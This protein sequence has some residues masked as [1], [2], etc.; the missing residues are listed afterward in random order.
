MQVMV[1][2]RAPLTCQ[3]KSVAILILDSCLLSQLSP[4][5]IFL[6]VFDVILNMD[7]TGSAMPTFQNTHLCG[8]GATTGGI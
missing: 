2:S 4:L 7:L 5:N 3:V 1:S 6:V 8:A